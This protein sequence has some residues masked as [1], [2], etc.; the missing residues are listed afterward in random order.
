MPPF[1]LQVGP[2]PEMRAR[3]VGDVETVEY[4]DRSSG[5]MDNARA[6][7]LLCKALREVAGCAATAPA[8][9][10]GSAHAA[11]KRARATVSYTH[12]RAHETSA[13]L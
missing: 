12:L 3:P 1:P 5:I 9:A 2:F 10:P 4:A 7:A 8:D 6:A 13:H 11:A